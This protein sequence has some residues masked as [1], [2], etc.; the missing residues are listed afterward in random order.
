MIIRK[1]GSY[2]TMSLYPNSNW[3]LDE[4]NYIIDE[5]TDEGKVLALMYS[6]NY[7]LVN[8]TV[9]ENNFVTG[10]SVIELERPAEVEG[11]YIDL[12]KNVGGGW[13][14]T[15]VDIPLTEEQKLQLKIANLEQENLNIMIATTDMYE[16][17]YNENL[18]LMLAITEL[19]EINMEV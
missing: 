8:F 10:V 6:E 9:G 11:K 4:D 2:E 15:Y 12:I 5:T 1:D 19:Y 17:Q 16:Q 14:Y 18:N 3:Y 13:E 7:P